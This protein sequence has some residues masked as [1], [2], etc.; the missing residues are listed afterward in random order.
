MDV[1][2]KSLTSK[3][4]TENFAAYDINQLTLSKFSRVLFHGVAPPMLQNTHRP[5]EKTLSLYPL[6]PINV[7]RLPKLKFL[8][9]GS[10]KM[11]AFFDVGESTY[12]LSLFSKVSQFYSFSRT[13][14]CSCLGSQVF[15]RILFF[16]WLAIACNRIYF[17]T[18]LTNT[19]I[20]TFF[21]ELFSLILRS[22][23]TPLFD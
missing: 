13:F 3:I 20:L 17:K 8:V 11:F 9:I 15:A 4:K 6:N 23:H 12:L 10:F 18:K 2:R 22:F 5:P 1:I 19:T 7:F 21:H 14:Y 16:I